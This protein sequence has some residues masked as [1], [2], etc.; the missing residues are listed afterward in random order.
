MGARLL[1]SNVAA[2][3]DCGIEPLGAGLT[4][5][6]LLIRIIIWNF[7]SDVK[8]SCASWMKR[9]GPLAVV[10]STWARAALTEYCDYN[11]CASFV[12]ATVE[13]SDV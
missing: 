4:A 1:R 2:K 9:S 5:P 11:S 7:L 6:A 10:I 3:S 8:A 13:A 12:S